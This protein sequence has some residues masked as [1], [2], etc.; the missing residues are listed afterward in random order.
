[1]IVFKKIR[2]RNFLSTGN[3]FTELD[4]DASPTTLVVGENGSGKSTVLDALCFALYNRPYRN[5]NKPQLCNSVNNKNTEVEIEF[6][7]GKNY[8]KIR[9]GMRP[10]VFEI[11]CNGT[12]VNQDAGSRDYQKYLEETILKMNFRTFTQIGILGT[13][14][15][16]PFMQLTQG[17]RR[18]LIEDILDI[19]IFTVMNNLLKVKITDLKDAITRADTE[20]KMAMHTAKIQ[21]EY[22]KTLQKDREERIAEI[23]AKILETNAEIAQAGEDIRNLEAQQEALQLTI[24]DRKDVETQKQQLEISLSKVDTE[25]KRL[26]KEIKFYENNDTCPTCEQVFDRYFKEKTITLRKAKVDEVKV[27]AKEISEKIDKLA[28]RLD[29]II[30]IK[31]NIDDLSQ[32]IIRLNQLIIT[33]ERHNQALILEKHD[34][35]TKVGNIELEKEKLRNFA[36]DVVKKTKAKSKLSEEKHYLET[37]GAL[38]KDTGI[39]TKIIRQY[40]PAINKLVNKY[41]AAMDFFVQFQLDEMFNESIKSRHRDEFSYFSFSE[42]EKQRIDLALLFTWRTIAKMKNSA[43]TN[44]L[45]LDEVFDSSLDANGTD[46]VMNLLNTIGEGTHVWVIS[47]KGDQLADKFKQI[48]RFEKK[49]NFSVLQTA[50]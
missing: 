5:I 12:M 48:I 4:L 19:Q 47:H 34:L 3:A 20:I 24:Q 25:F 7:V 44:I 18:D 9:R 26:L 32:Q 33:Q 37:A 28:T 23:E 36:K 16:K 40:L 6:L 2:W 8:Y 27:S 10:I 35:Q 11:Y 45:F 50:N 39:K 38:L 43:A 42:G 22:I 29:E 30:G 15:F 13:A 17:Q 14:S 1:M 31:D 49:Q 41:L 46:Y 21:E